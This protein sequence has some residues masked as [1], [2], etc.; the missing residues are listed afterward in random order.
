M[1][2]TTWYKSTHNGYNCRC[3]NY[4][5]KVSA[6]REETD[7]LSSGTSKLKTMLKSKLN[8]FKK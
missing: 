1:E 2:I 7:D 5:P 8:T 3:I 4:K 6:T